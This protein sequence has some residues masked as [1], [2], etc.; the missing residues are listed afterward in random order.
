MTYGETI[1]RLRREKVGED[2]YN[3]PVY[4]D[5][6][7]ELQ[8][9][10]FDP[11]D[12]TE[13]LTAGGAASS[14]TPTLYFYKSK[15]DIVRGDQIQVRGVKYQVEGDPGVWVSPFTGQLAGTTVRLTRSEGS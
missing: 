11:G 1:T 13:S 9:A 15:P 12:A 7:T 8:G 2:R 3:Q 10:G 5:V 6:P 4:G 14:T